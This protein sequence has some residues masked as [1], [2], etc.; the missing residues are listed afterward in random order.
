MKRRYSQPALK[1]QKIQGL[2]I[3]WMFWGQG[4]GRVKENFQVLS[5]VIQHMAIDYVVKCVL[6]RR[7]I[8]SEMVKL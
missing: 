4:V 6:G 3:D 1:K 2:L 8:S 5:L 7:I